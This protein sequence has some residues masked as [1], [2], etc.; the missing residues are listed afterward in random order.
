MSYGK[1]YRPSK[2]T[3]GYRDGDTEDGLY[4]TA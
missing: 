2:F 4:I 3:I 1:T